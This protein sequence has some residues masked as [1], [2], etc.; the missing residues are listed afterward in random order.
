[1]AK[2]P[3]DHFSRLTITLITELDEQ[4]LSLMRQLQRTRASIHHR[5]PIPERIG[6]NTDIVICEYTPDLSRRYSWMPGEAT[7][8]SIM[9]L[10]QSEL[11]DIRGLQAALPDAVIHRPYHSNA[12]LSA[13]VVG[14]DHFSF[15][16][17]Q[18]T[19]IA[20]LDENVR[21]LRH[22]ERAKQLIMA[23]KNINE[24]KAFNVLRTMA[25]E[26]RMSIAAL[27]EY[28]VDSRENL[29]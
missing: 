27:A 5:W 16:R 1:M 13:L 4:G 19:R 7:A 20:R 23:D 2:N 24:H 17:R 6:E 22:I 11:F 15:C 25:M 18:R 29:S 9:L 3:L 28:L 12:V 10:P 26:R 8:A 14:W 21:N